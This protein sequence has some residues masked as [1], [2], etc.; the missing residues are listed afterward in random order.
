MRKQSHF[1]FNK[2]ERSGIFFLLL[3]V[4][5]LQCVYYLV[6]ANPATLEHR[7]ALNVVEQSKLDSLKIQQFE[8]S[9]RIFPFNPNYI[10]DY[11][12]YTLGLSSTEW[13]RLSAFRKEGNFVNSAEEFQA[14]TQV[15]DS[16]LHQMAPYFN[17][18]GF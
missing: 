3:I 15:S 14:V 6:K 18:Y 9:Q 7:F 5:L 17:L 8:A 12:A 10:S 11:K 4:V 16:L 1:R 2:Q 13:D